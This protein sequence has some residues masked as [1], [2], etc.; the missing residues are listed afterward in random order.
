MVFINVGE[1]GLSIHHWEG[2]IMPVTSCCLCEHHSDGGAG[3]LRKT[4]GLCLTWSSCGLRDG[5][6]TG[7]LPAVSVQKISSSKSDAGDVPT[8]TQRGSSSTRKPNTS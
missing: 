5:V 1:A 8:L 7:Q 4:S 2:H 3:L 6:M